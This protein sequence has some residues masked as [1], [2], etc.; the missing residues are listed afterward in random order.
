MQTL[1]A[2]AHF[3]FNLAGAYSYEQALVTIR[4]LGLPMSAIEQQYRRMV[5]NIVIR[6][7]DDHVKNIAFLMDKKGQW[8][9]SPAYDVTY[10]Y[11]PTG[12]WT[13]THQMTMNGKRENFTL[14]DFKSCAKVALMKRGQEKL[15]IAEVLDVVSNWR[16]YAKDAGIPGQTSDRIYQAL[17]LDGF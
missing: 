17:R 3:D 5:F 9:L 1:C 11:N 7:Q 4:Q 6:N 12:R 15:I 10:S 13:A 2:L 14:A 8:K 16:K